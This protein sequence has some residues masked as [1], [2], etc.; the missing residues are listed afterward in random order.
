MCQKVSTNW[1]SQTWQEFDQLCEYNVVETQLIA[2]LADVREPC[3]LGCTGLS[4]CSNFNNRY[5]HWSSLLQ[6]QQQVQTL[7]LSGTTSTTGTDTGALWNHS[8]SI[9]LVELL[10]VMRY[11]TRYIIGP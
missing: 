1:G 2:C 3:Q 5:R 9:V 11:R 8:L 4:Y 7:E 10:T 6:L